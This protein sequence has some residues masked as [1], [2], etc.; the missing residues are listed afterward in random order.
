MPRTASFQ[1]ARVLGIRIA[2]DASWFVVLFL[3]IVLLSGSFQQALG[4]SDLVAY[5][6]AVAAVLLFFA[7]VTLHE[8]GHAV[9]ARRQGIGVDGIDLWFFG[10]LMRMSRDTDSAGA[11]LKVAVAGP[12]VTLA[13]VVLCAAGGL[14]V[15]GE[16]EFRDALAFSE[17]GSAPGVLILA[18]LLEINAL[19]FVINLLP[20][21][22]LDGGRIARAVAWWHTGSRARATR[23]AAGLGRLFSLA[24]IGL[25]IAALFGPG[26]LINGLWLIVFG[27]FIGQA[28]RGAIVQSALGERI[29]GVRVSD[30]MDDQPV[31]VPADLPAGRTLE[32]FFLRYG[33]DWFPVVEPGGALRGLLHRPAA[34][35]AAPERLA[36]DLVA[37]GEPDTRV[38]ADEP[39]EVLLG[40]EPLRRHGALMAVDADGRLAGVVTARQVAR[41]LRERLGP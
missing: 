22:P 17:Q 30:V 10:G 8:L 11:E 32:E 3:F 39:L 1:L 26:G 9:A 41:V 31:T 15:A 34:E 7:S 23:F 36:G 40:S 25:G 37:P 4:G 5:A 28:A 16:R 18:W 27:L 13:V 24:I 20:A 35:A 29:E 38:R 33:W 21:F 2:V 14:A 19:L 12:A 6:A